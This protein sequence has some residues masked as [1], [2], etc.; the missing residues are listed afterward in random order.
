MH[1]VIYD[2]R[3]LMEESWIKSDQ[4]WRR[5]LS[6]ECLYK[7]ALWRDYLHGIKSIVIKEHPRGACMLLRDTDAVGQYSYYMMS[8]FV[9]QNLIDGKIFTGRLYNGNIMYFATLTDI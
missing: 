4:Y 6:A 9:F 3:V 8:M 7:S 1:N 2:I 5:I